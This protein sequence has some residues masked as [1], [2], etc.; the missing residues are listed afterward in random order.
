MASHINSYADDISLFNTFQYGFRS[1]YG[2]DSAILHLLEFVRSGFG[3]KFITLA[4][5]VDLRRA[6]ECV[7]HDLILCQLVKIGASLA[8]VKW[9]ASFFKDRMFSVSGLN[10][11]SSQHKFGNRGVHQVSGLASLLFLLIIDSLIRLLYQ[12]C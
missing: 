8:L 1:G 9:F 7:P 11:L 6:F 2:T 5:F 3:R 4:L 10:G 12:Y